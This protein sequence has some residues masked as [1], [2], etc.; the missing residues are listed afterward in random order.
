MAPTA[1]DVAAAVRRADPAFAAVTRRHGPPPSHR[2]IRVDRRFAMLA[3]AILHQQLAGAAARAIHARVCALVGD[4][5][6][7]EAVLRADETALAA[8]GVSGPKRASLLDLA[9]KSLDG[10]IDFASMARRSDDLVVETLCEVRG[11]GVWT[12]QMFCLNA[13]GRR[14]VWPVGDLGVRMGWSQL[15]GDGEPIDARDLVP[16]GEPFRPHRSAVAWYCWRAVEDA[17]AERSSG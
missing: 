3:T 8:C 12:A 15:H 5:M 7:P 2:P 9:V 17:R 11:V 13:L 6:T 10:T 1:T 14:D 4:P 16:L